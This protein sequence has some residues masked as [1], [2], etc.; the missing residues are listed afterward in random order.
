MK[1]F[2]K[3]TVFSTLVAVV[4]SSA[5]AAETA[6]N[7]TNFTPAQVTQI[8]DIIKDY[9]IHNPEVLV[10]A[11]QT[12][13]RQQQA[14]MQETSLG[15]IAQNKTALFDDAQSPSIGSQTAPTTIVEFFDYQ[16]GHCKEMAPI[17]EKVVTGDKNLRV[18]F[19]ELPIFGAQSQYAAKAALAANMQPGKYYAFHNALLNSD[20]PLN[21]ETVM[22]IAKKTGL[23]IEKLNKDMNSP[24][25][26]K[27]LQDNFK[28]AEA[29]RIPG[30][31][32]FVISNKAQTTFR[33]IPGATSQQDLQ[34]QIKAVG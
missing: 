15:A 16:C 31:P 19:K 22:G 26:A 34:A 25:I 28:L 29:L 12:L 18:I 7:N 6:P 24:E 13:Q 11:S 32:A 17:V 27:Q 20:G 2:I 10:E 1:H 23:N 21:T 33:Y 9:L 4:A 8:Q 14:K 5:L 3:A 30:T